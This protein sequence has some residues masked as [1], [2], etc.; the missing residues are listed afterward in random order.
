[1]DSGNKYQYPIN[2]LNTIEI[3]RPNEFSIH[4]GIVQNTSKDNNP[5]ILSNNILNEIS[6]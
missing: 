4:G 5:N 6:K 2:N 1:M 3:D